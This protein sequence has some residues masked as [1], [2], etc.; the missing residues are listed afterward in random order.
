MPTA[1]FPEKYIRGDSGTIVLRLFTEQVPSACFLFS[2]G[3][4]TASYDGEYFQVEQ[5]GQDKEAIRILRKMQSGHTTFLWTWEDGLHHLA[6]QDTGETRV[7]NSRFELGAVIPAPLDL[8]GAPAFPGSI[9]LLETHVTGLVGE[10]DRSFI[11]AG[12]AY[13]SAIADGLLDE[14]K[15]QERAHAFTGLLPTGGMLFGRDFRDRSIRYVQKPY[16][17]L[18]PAPVDH[19]PLLVAD[20]KGPLRRQYFFDLETGDYTDTNTE[21]FVLEK[22]TTF[23]LSY[24]GLDESFPP[25]VTIQGETIP[26]LSV[27][28]PVVKLSLT[29]AEHEQWYGESVR[30]TYKL[31]RAYHVEW[32]GDA[33]H[34][35]LI[36]QLS[37]RQDVPVTVTQEGNRHHT[38]RLATEIE[39]NPIVNP[40]HTGFLYIDKEEQSGQAFRMNLSSPYVLTDGMDSADLIVELIDQNGNE[41]LSPYLDVFVADRTSARQTHYGS[42]VPIVTLDTLEARNRAG[43]CFFRYRAPLL[44]GGA[45]EELFLVAYDRQSGLGAQVPLRLRQPHRTNPA[46]E[47]L[48]AYAEEGAPEAALPFEYFAR[49]YGRRIPDG[50]PL[51]A[52]DTD[53][54]G[55]LTHRDWLAFRNRLQDAS[56][57]AP[58][59]AA[60]KEQEEF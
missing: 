29:E 14:T 50:H 52:C 9:V 10:P 2:L 41:V 16:F 39:L 43:R 45:T 58:L 57:L 49:H 26:V 27:D 18:T 28:G 37:D 60:L 8:I 4:W 40:Q 59:A 1:T 15:P 20:E 34:D 32:N 21:T 19:S 33:A 48:L 12:L 55:I 3:S 11:D 47:S 51:A 17:E 5:A 54:D 53:G 38:V 31:D 6:V 23:T 13:Q 30:I 42:L 25:L 36:V 22:K 46:V 24:D 35:S 56:F 44:V 7:T